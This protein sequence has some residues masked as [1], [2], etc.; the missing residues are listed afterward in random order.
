VEVAAQLG[1]LQG[2][3]EGGGPVR[4]VR[5]R[6]ATGGSMRRRALQVVARWG[7]S[8]GGW[9]DAT[10]GSPTLTCMWCCA[11]MSALR[12]GLLLMELSKGSASAATATAASA[13]APAAAPPLARPPSSTSPST[14]LWRVG[15]GVRL[16]GP[17]R[18]R[19]GS[20]LAP[21]VRQSTG[22]GWGSALHQNVG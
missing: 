13:P 8:A 6:G 17:A 9:R 16:L 4:Q 1:Q 10:A 7:S 22:E 14:D 2:G 11:A 3:G 20:G 5:G 12:A 18:Q 15:G 21:Q 19:L